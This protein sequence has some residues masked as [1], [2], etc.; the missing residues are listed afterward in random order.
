LGKFEPIKTN[1]V[2]KQ[3][4]DGMND[5][6]T[7]EIRVGS[8]GLINWEP[9]PIIEVENESSL[10]EI[11]ALAAAY[12]T[13]GATVGTAFGSQANI[14]LPL[15]EDIEKANNQLFNALH[16]K[17]KSKHDQFPHSQPAFYVIK[18][19][20]QVITTENLLNAIHEHI[21]PEDDYRWITG[22]VL[23]TPRQGFLQTD[24]DAD[25]K[26]SINPR[27]KYPISDSFLSIFTQGTQFH[28]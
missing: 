5:S 27:A 3:V 22:I 28:Y 14:A 20:H 19:G 8:K 10:P 15:P 16:N 12:T 6:P 11:H 21:W 1:E 24:K 7:G 4:L 9:F 23:F 13:P 18:I 17:L 25:L 26:L 2:I